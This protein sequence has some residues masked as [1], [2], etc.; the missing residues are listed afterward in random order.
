MRWIRDL[1]TLTALIGLTAVSIAGVFV[2][3]R[4][5]LST[6]PAAVRRD[7]WTQL[8]QTD[9][10]SADRSEQ[11]AALSELEESLNSAADWQ[12]RAAELTVEQRERL[13]ANLD[14][15]GPLWLA[16]EAERYFDRPPES[17]DDYLD[18]RIT[19]LQQ[20]ISAAKNIQADGANAVPGSLLTDAPLMLNRWM[21]A[22]E[23]ERR[24]QTQKFVQAAVF[25]FLARRR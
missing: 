9:L 8:I 12:T 21:E 3:A 20:L 7:G 10:A 5:S 2:A 4:Q 11:R 17:R 16:D 23:P 18:R 15:L 14:V 6:P 19:Q 22:I 1:I 24:E 13:V 25:R